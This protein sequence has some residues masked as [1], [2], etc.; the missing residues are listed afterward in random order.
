MGLGMGSS[1]KISFGSL[2]G[3]AGFLGSGVGSVA[4]VALSASLA[5]DNFQ[6]R[7]YFLGCI[8]SLEL[9]SRV[10]RFQV[11]GLPVR[12]SVSELAFQ[13]SV[14]EQGPVPRLTWAAVLP[15]MVGFRGL[16]PFQLAL[17]S[18]QFSYPRIAHPQISLQKW[19]RRTGSPFYYSA[20][21]QASSSHLH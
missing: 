12:V 4:D 3:F 16:A 6:A 13:F 19:S 11:P 15:M 2:D 18:I 7:I 21:L 8:R 14:S 10:F 9:S 17:R 5:L 1:Q 20:Q